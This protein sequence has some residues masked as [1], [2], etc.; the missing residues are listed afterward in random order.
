MRPEIQGGERG[1][2]H[3][4]RSHL[5]WICP[6]IGLVAGATILWLF[7]IGLWTMVA[8]LFLIAWPFVVAWVLVI[9]R[10]ENIASRKQP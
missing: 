3:L 10:Q 9:E 1:L 7:G 4:T 2:F 6:I 5:L 8:F